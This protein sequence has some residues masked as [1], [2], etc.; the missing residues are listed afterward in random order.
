M[1]AASKSQFMSQ[2]QPREVGLPGCLGTLISW[3]CLGDTCLPAT[4][5]SAE[6]RLEAT[7]WSR[8]GKPAQLDEKGTP[9]QDEG[10]KGQDSWEPG[11][12][13]LP[14]A[15]HRDAF[16]RCG[17][18]AMAAFCSFSVR[19]CRLAQARLKGPKG[20]REIADLRLAV[21]IYYRFE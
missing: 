3:G 1:A 13:R 2:C 16:Q 6:Q 8:G 4:A 21:F 12:A 15:R 17:I 11:A 20:G 19:S 5:R 7:A 10:S 18:I 9:R 14:F